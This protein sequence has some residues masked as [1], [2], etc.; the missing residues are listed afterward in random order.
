M[1]LKSEPFWFVTCDGCGERC[2]YVE[3]AAWQ[4]PGSAI[5]E[6]AELDWTQDGEKWFC[7]EC[8]DAA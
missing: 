4:E 6:A 7:P 2:D 3:Y 8:R 5:D 1:P